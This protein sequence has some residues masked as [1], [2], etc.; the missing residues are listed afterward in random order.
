MI[1][2]LTFAALLLLAGWAWGL[3]VLA[4]C[5]GVLAGCALAARFLLARDAGG[6]G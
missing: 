5:G 1:V 3:P 6:E 4:V 2:T